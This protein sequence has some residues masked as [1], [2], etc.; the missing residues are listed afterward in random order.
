MFVFFEVCNCTIVSLDSCLDIASWRSTNFTPLGMCWNP[1]FLQETAASIHAILI[2]PSKHRNQATIQKS[3]S[4]ITK[5]HVRCTQKVNYAYLK[6]YLL[7]EV[8]FG[9]NII[10]QLNNNSCFWRILEL[11]LL[12]FAARQAS[13]AGLLERSERF[14]W[15]MVWNHDVVNVA[16]NTH[17]Y[18]WNT[19]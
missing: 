18:I 10:K 1:G 5:K 9:T 12:G 15:N 7:Q 8:V 2:V 11:H 13:T 17:V 4:F 3:P 19:E 6:P 16:W 14:G